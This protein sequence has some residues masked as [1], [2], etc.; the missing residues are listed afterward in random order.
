ML[1][2]TLIAGAIMGFLTWVATNFLGNPI[3]SLQK[4]RREA[5]GVAS[6]YYHVNHSSTDAL[7]GTA[8]KALNDVGSTLREYSLESSIATRLWCR[9]RQYNL[10]LASRCLFGLAECARGES[11]YDEETRKNTLGALYISLNA[12]RHMTPSEV[13]TVKRKVAET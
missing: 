6:R 9:L 11:R 8:S 2:L 12:T 13:D 7:R 4:K 10:N 1:G 3:L 5:L